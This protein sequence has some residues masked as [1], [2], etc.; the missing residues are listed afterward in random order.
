MKD[1]DDELLV[2]LKRRV[3]DLEMTCAFQE[4]ALSKLDEVLRAFA[5]RVDGLEADV[6]RL[7]SAKAQEPIGPQNDPPPHY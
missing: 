5:D 3:E 4:R 1:E 7:S 6:L 2:V